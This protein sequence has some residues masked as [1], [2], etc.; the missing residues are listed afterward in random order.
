[1]QAAPAD[2]TA[3][4]WVTLSPSDDSEVDPSS[5]LEIVF[6]E[7]VQA[8]T[9]DITITVNGAAQTVGVKTAAVKINTEKVTID[10]ANF[11]AGAAVSVVV[12]EG[13]FVDKAGN[14][15]AGFAAGAWN[16]TTSPAPEPTDNT[17]PAVASLSPDDD[18]TEVAENASYRS[19][20]AKKLKPGAAT[21]PSRSMVP[22]RQ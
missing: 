12:P 16:F 9:G 10:V 5:K 17:V 13:A 6:S 11:P 3:P 19:P 20:S 8:G 7:E 21:L 2:N 4:V 14:A 15:F 18:A 1:M 22:L